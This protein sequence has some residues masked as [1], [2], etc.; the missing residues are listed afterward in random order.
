MKQNFMF[1]GL[2]FLMASVFSGSAMDIYVSPGGTG[3]ADGSSKYPFHTIDQARNQARNFVG[4]EAVTIHLEDGGIQAYP[5]IYRAVNTGNAIVSGG[6][7]LSVQWAPYLESI[8]AK[9]LLATM[10]VSILGGGIGSGIRIFK[11]WIKK[12][13][14]IRTCL[15]WI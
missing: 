8:L 5:V 10:G 9:V 11:R 14:P 7:L 12:F 4:K 15:S 3:K 6:R 13:L 1:P 2:L